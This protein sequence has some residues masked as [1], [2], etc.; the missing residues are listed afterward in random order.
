MTLGRRVCVCRIRDVACMS[1]VV[2]KL[3]LCAS[4]QDLCHSLYRET[5]RYSCSCICA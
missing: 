5:P 2:L 3:Y 1:V 4:D